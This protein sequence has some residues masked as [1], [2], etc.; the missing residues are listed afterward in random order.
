MVIVTDLGKEGLVAGVVRFGLLA[1]V[2]FSFLLSLAGPFCSWVL[3]WSE[4]SV[5]EDLEARDIL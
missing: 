1:A 5:R 4:R 3:S 2:S